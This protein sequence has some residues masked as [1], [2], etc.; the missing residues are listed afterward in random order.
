MWEFL[1]GVFFY[2]YAFGSSLLVIGLSLLFLVFRSM[3]YPGESAEAEQ[4][5]AAQITTQRKQKKKNII[6]IYYGTETGTAQTFAQKLYKDLLAVGPS[7]DVIQKPLCLSGVEVEHLAEL[8]KRFDAESTNLVYIFLVSTHTDGQPPEKASWFCKSMEEHA[9][10]FRVP[11]TYLQNIKYTVF[12]LGNS[13]YGDNYN[14][15]GKQLDQNIHEL[16]A[17]RLVDLG[18]GN[19]NT[20][21]S[22]HGSLFSDF[23]EWKNALIAKLMFYD[24]PRVSLVNKKRFVISSTTHK[25]SKVEVAKN[26]HV[27]N[28][29]K[30]VPEEQLVESSSEDEETVVVTHG[31]QNSNK[32]A[33]LVDLEDIGTVMSSARKKILAEK[34]ERANGILREMVTPEMRQILTKQGYKIIGSHSGVKLCRWTK[35]MLRGRG[36][37]YKHTFYGIQSH[38]CMEATPSLAC[39]NKCTFCWR[40]NSHPVGTEWKWQMD[41][42][43][44]IVKEGLANHYKMIK[45]FQGVPG[46][47]KER[48]DEG[49]K[50]RHCALSLVGEP[51]MYPQINKF[52]RLL[53]DE[54]VSTFLV[55]NAQFPDAII[56]LSPVTQLYVSVDASTK[57][58]LKKIDRP[59]FKDFWERFL[60]SL[61]ALR[62]KGQ[63]TVYRLTLVKSWNMDELENYAKLV[64]L[65]NPDFIE[66]KGVTY[67][68]TSKANKLTMEN[69]PWHEDVVHFSQ[70][71]CNMLKNYE[72]ACEHEHSNC[73]LLANTRFKVDGEWHT[74]IDYAKFHTLVQKFYETGDESSFTA[75]DYMVKTPNWAVYGSTERGFDPDETRW[76]R[77]N[78]TKD[79]SGC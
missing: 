61:K 2:C 63:R 47:T 75:S 72:L 46:V 35:A 19:E 79:I 78:N 52:I 50:A 7:N 33:G 74:W 49:L 11:K 24:E 25:L 37:C 67:C 10:D 59:L 34:S 58:S 9:N 12:G 41:D 5:E 44:K 60:A 66:I 43:E 23:D 69:V 55:T 28:G 40:H 77:K 16:G 8:V 13:D 73:I 48:I 38:Q 62:D 56:N 36:G 6:K 65:G 54:Q 32:S 42:A 30:K 15:V 29:V 31:D 70:Q 14:L 39:A 68:G 22:I 27:P 3:I 53:H 21:E 51:I 45:E 18:L 26:G 76:K 17:I 4:S 57:D 64:D 20:A 71:L 1:E